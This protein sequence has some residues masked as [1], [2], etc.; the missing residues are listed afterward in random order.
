MAKLRQI[1]RDELESVHR[2]FQNLQNELVRFLEE[3]PAP[4]EEQIK[5]AL[6]M[7]KTFLG[8]SIRFEHI[9]GYSDLRCD[10][11]LK[12]YF[13]LKYRRDTMPLPFSIELA[14]PAPG[15]W[16]PPLI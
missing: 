4:L 2:V 10:Q 12:V 13:N 7:V 15:Q 11:N 16:M 8:R 3:N 14:P 6:G 9:I 1:T 5:T